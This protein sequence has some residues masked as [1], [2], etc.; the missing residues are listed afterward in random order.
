MK[1]LKEFDCPKCDHSF[2]GEIDRHW[3]ENVCEGGD[4]YCSCG[5][6]TYFHECPKCGEDAEWWDY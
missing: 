1:E 4:E 3:Y 6:T 5:G 2:K